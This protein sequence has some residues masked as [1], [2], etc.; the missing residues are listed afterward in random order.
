MRIKKPT[1]LCERTK[2]TEWDVKIWNRFV[3]INYSYTLYGLT[4]F[5]TGALVKKMK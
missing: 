2:V 1:D 5:N 4:L 3:Y